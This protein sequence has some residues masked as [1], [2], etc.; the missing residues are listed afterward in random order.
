MAN[1]VICAELKAGIDL[2]CARNITK[3]YYQQAVIINYN[4]I[5]K[6]ASV[7]PVLSPICDASVEMILKTGKAGFPFLLSDNGN[8]VK[9][10][11]DKST[12]DKGIVEYLHKVDFL[13]DEAGCKLDSLDHG[14][15]VVA[16]Q[17]RDG[18]VEIYGWNN[19]LSTADYTF[20]R[21]ESGGLPLITLQSN[22]NTKEGMP[23]L[24]YKAT[25]PSTPEADFNAAFEQA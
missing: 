6:E 19:G 21:A 17:R 12:T 10:Y 16:L 5:D 11:F 13:I 24:V 20:D 25:A 23:P 7:D 15:F 3:S 2:S 1:T 9:G 8:A 14:R 22:E 4:D 18:V